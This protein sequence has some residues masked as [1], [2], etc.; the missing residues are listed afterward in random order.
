MRRIRRSLPV[1][2]RRR[3]VTQT[4]TSPNQCVGTARGS[5]RGVSVASEGVPGDCY[6]DANEHL[7]QNSDVPARLDPMFGRG[8]ATASNGGTVTITLE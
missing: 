1:A 8:T 4:E 3:M 6:S 7:L 5:L 2:I